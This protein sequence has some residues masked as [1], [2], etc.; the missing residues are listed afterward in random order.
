MHASVRDFVARQVAGLG[1]AGRSAV[2]VGS[3]DVNGGV[4]GL[5]TGRYVGVDMRAGPGVDVVAQAAA[6]PFPDNAFEAAV[7]TE[8]LEHDTR[9]W[10]SIAEMARVLRPAGIL[11]LTCRGFDQRGCF[12]LHEYPNDLWRFTVG[13]IGVL[14]ADAGLAAL[15]VIEDPQAPGVFAAARKPNAAASR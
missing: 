10:L 3:Y 5:F 12:Q 15:E 1:L 13:S 8:M 6:L 7:C 2:E 9:P 14:L 11:L 4:R